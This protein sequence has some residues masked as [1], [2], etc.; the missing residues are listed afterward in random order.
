MRKALI[1]LLLA[2]PLAAADL[3][4]KE[5]FADP[6]TREVALARLVPKTRDWFFHHALHH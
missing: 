3:D 2:L 5:A 4:F 6:A 1:S